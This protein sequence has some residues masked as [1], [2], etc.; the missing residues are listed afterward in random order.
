MT[1]NRQLKSTHYRQRGSSLLVSVVM[2]V[3][4]TM[5]VVSAIQMSNVN[6]KTLGNAQVTNE[7]QEAALQGI[8]QVMGDI[9]NFYTPAAQNINIDVNS[10]GTTKSTYA[11]AMS[12]PVCEKMVAVAGYSADFADSAPKDTYWDVKAVATDGRTGASATVHQG[13]KVR[14]DSSATCP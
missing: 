4:L 10:S 3:V 6:L 11:V 1:L 7:A 12:A 9:G 14:M 8:E 2:L 5:L 13:V